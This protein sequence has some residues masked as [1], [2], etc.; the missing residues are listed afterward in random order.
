MAPYFKAGRTKKT[1]Q[2]FLEYCK[3]LGATVIKGQEITT[4]LVFV[5]H[6]TALNKDYLEKEILSYIRCDKKLSIQAFGITGHKSHKALLQAGFKKH[7]VF[8]KSLYDSILK[9]EDRYLLDS[10]EVL[11]MGN[12]ISSYPVFED[13]N[14]DY[15][16]AI[17]TGLSF[18]T[19]TSIYLFLRNLLKFLNRVGKNDN[20]II[21]LHTA[22]DNEPPFRVGRLFNLFSRDNFFWKVAGN[23]LLFTNFLFINLPL[24]NKKVRDS[25]TGAMYRKV[26]GR[27]VPLSQ[28][29]DHW[30]FGAEL[31]MPGIR[32][33][34]ITGRSSVVWFALTQKVPVFNCDAE[35][36]YFKTK[37]LNNH[38]D[39]YGVPFYDDNL[40]FDRQHWKRVPA[41]N[42]KFDLIKFILSEVASCVNN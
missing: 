10:L 18:E 17:P 5:T 16:I 34:L 41:T 35:R 39:H 38:F 8:D 9:E 6:M 26:L 2:L 13:F 3:E 21:K 31:F 7:I 20:I 19:E 24:K 27:C 42:G 36:R 1:N 22:R 14:C 11:E 40:D 33:G 37:Y 23:V 32:K 12:I 25:I 15:M 4:K 29:H 28:I 30:N